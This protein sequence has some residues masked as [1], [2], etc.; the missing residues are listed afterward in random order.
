M[1][2][3]EETVDPG[4]VRRV[5]DVTTSSG[6]GTVADDLLVDLGV[7]RSLSGELTALGTQMRAND[8]TTTL[9]PVTAAMVS[10]DVAVACVAAGPELVAAL[11]ALAGRVDTTSAAVGQAITAYAA[12]EAAFQEQL[13]HAGGK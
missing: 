13:R 1:I 2:S 3:K 7:L 10:S 6:G 8:P 9:V 12:A 5:R 11:T 4:Y